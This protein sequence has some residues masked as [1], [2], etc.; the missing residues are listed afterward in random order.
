MFS[1]K[2]DRPIGIPVL[3]CFAYVGMTSVLNGSVLPTPTQ[4]N[5]NPIP[6]DLLF[7]LI[8]IS[9]C[10][11]IL[12][13]GQ[14][15]TEN[16]KLWL[17][18]YKNTV[19]EFASHPGAILTQSVPS[20]SPTRITKFLP[21]NSFDDI[22]HFSGKHW[23]K[24]RSTEVRL[25]MKKLDTCVRKFKE[26][27]IEVWT[28]FLREPGATKGKDTTCKI[29]RNKQLRYHSGLGTMANSAER[30]KQDLQHWG[31]CAEDLVAGHLGLHWTLSG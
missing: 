15:K 16:R 13:K 27:L 30:L 19:G 24:T 6:V 1:C 31:C 4:C 11:G 5:P 9:Q 28:S 25:K 29:T 10:S 21:Q 22:L 17:L 12:W 2:H 14:P 20:P 18:T 8:G 3:P 26:A 7:S 23:R